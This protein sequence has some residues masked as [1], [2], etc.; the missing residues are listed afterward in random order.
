LESADRIIERLGRP[1]AYEGYH[2]R[3]GASIGVASDFGRA[4]D[5]RQLLRNSDIAL[6]QA[7]RQGRN[8]CVFFSL[9]AQAS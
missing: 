8:R 6:Y 7:K 9:Q 2:C 4:I 5:V 3:V 1:V